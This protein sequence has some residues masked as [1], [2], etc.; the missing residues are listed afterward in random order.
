MKIE[1]EVLARLQQIFESGIKYDGHDWRPEQKILALRKADHAVMRWDHSPFAPLMTQEAATAIGK[2]AVNFL[3][4]MLFALEGKRTVMAIHTIA[5]GE[6]IIE[7]APKIQAVIDE[8]A[9]KFKWKNVRPVSVNRLFSFSQFI[10]PQKVEDIQKFVLRSS[11][12]R[13]RDEWAEFYDFFKKATE[14]GKEGHVDMHHWS[15]FSGGKPLPLNLGSLNLALDET[16]DPDLLPSLKLRQQDSLK[17]DILVVTH[18]MLRLLTW[19]LR[20]YDHQEKSGHDIKND[21]GAYEFLDVDEAHNLPRVTRSWIEEMIWLDTIRVTLDQAP[22][23]MQESQERFEALEDYVRSKVLDHRELHADNPDEFQPLI[24]LLDELCQP[25]LRIYDAVDDH[26]LFQAKLEAILATLAPILALT[27]RAGTSGADYRDLADADVYPILM[28]RGTGVGIKLKAGSVARSI[29]PIWRRG[30]DALNKRLFKSVYMVSGTLA[31]AKI[32]IRDP[33]RHFR[34]DI[35]ASRASGEHREAIWYGDVIASSSNGHVE[36]VVYVEHSIDLV[37]VIVDAAGDHVA[38]PKHTQFMA[39]LLGYIFDLK[40]KGKNR[41]LALFMS[42]RAMLETADALLR[43]FPA[44][45]PH[46][47]VQKSGMRFVGSTLEGFREDPQAILFSMNWQGINA[48][49]ED[50]RSLVDHLVLTKVPLMPADERLSRE[51]STAFS[52]KLLFNEAHWLFRQGI[53]R[54]ARDASAK[55]TLWLGDPRIPLPDQLVPPYPKYIRETNETVREHY[56]RFN[57]VISNRLYG[58]GDKSRT[59]LL[60]GSVRLGY[61]RRVD[62]DLILHEHDVILT[63]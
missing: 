56:E 17:A 12:R 1:S 3:L 49:T 43:R 41:I 55:F 32:D 30:Q 4:A 31:D 19:K 16:S 37:P 15:E 61:I 58:R 57:N 5:L 11:S 45:E 10:S 13:E 60:A 2:T 40:A 54:G 39:Q 46:L 44:L 51:Y 36:R 53:G 63:T 26:P 23:D 14:G 28:R 6:Q 48:V 21:P 29:S 52:L 35:G 20:S 24:D 47:I 27:K 18:T 62:Q 22:I 25:L 59:G 9:R 50:G 42:E 8:A 38:N 7:T 33:Y 34:M